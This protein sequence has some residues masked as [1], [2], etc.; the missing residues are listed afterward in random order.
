MSG[1]EPPRGPTPLGHTVCMVPPPLWGKRSLTDEGNQDQFEASS[2]RCKD[3][4]TTP[5]KL[6]GPHHS[7]IQ[8]L[9]VQCSPAVPDIWLQQPS[10]LSNTE[11]LT[12]VECLH[13]AEIQ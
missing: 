1:E 13:H 2:P 5:L 3:A 6:S 7:C 9:A 11:L 8:V 4:V 12:S 10:K